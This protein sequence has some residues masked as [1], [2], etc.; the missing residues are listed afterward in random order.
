[1]IDYYLVGGLWSEQFSQDLQDQNVR[2]HATGLYQ[3]VTSPRFAIYEATGS[4]CT[5][6]YHLRDAIDQLPVYSPIIG[7]PYWDNYRHSGGLFHQDD[8][9]GY[10]S[11]ISALGSS[12]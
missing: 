10:I 2:L 7:A 6:P 3:I 12:S 5:D 9:V 8:A 4:H 1:M 11:G